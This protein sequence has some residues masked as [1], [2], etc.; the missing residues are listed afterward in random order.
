[1]LTSLHHKNNSCHYL[2]SLSGIDNLSRVTIPVI[3]YNLSQAYITLAECDY[4]AQAL[5]FTYP[6][7][8]F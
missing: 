3:T 6:N 8:F 1:M 7:S 4:P 5:W 2:Q